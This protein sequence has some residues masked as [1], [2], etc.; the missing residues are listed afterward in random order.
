M[1]KTE[2]ESIREVRRKARELRLA[3]K[4]AADDSLDA[5]RRLDCIADTLRANARRIFTKTEG[6]N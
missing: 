1:D 6:G 5:A 4:V 2:T 3:A